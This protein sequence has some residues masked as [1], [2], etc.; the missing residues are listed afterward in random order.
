M[1]HPMAAVLSLADWITPKSD[2]I[3]VQTPTWLD[4]QGREVVRA[5]RRQGHVRVTWLVSERLGGEDTFESVPVRLKSSP[6]G[7]G[8]YLRAKV[9]LHTHGLGN[10]TE[11][12]SR[13]K[14]FLN[15]WHGMPLKRLPSA[16]AT[17]R[18]QTTR[19]I[20]T[21]DGHAGHIAGS[22]GL[23]AAQVAVT[24]LPRNDV[25]VRARTT[26]T[27]AIDELAGGKPVVVWLPTFRASTRG[28]GP[29]DGC[30]TGNVFQLPGVTT[31][32]VNAIL[33]ELG[34]F[35]IVKPHRNSPRVETVAASHIAVWDDAALDANGLTVYELLARSTALITDY[36]S[37]WVDY[38]LVDRPII[39]AVADLAAYQA[40][41]GFYVADL[42]DQLPG[43]RVTDLAEL[44]DAL[45]TLVSGEDD[46]QPVR[47]AMTPDHH[48]HVDGASADRV[49]RIALSLLGSRLPAGN[50]R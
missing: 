17:S 4:D 20:A 49:A 30:E 31:S 34:I 3:V 25:L 48:A 45:R 29:P 24:G 35:L 9:V 7:L 38:L 36:S 8:S 22:W 6:R 15:L 33:R 18:R 14:A 43:P 47:Q 26:A 2:S 41:R 46:W 44:R 39:F 11:F 23:A 16:T 1:T 50:D 19:T 21:S 27:P 40:G 10:L 42:A 32:H 5:L 13:R 28:D 37:V 12:P